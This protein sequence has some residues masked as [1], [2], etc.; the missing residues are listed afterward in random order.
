MSTPNLKFELSP[1]DSLAESFTSIPGQQY[2]SL[3]HT[4]GSME[5]L[6]AMTPQSFDGD[7]MFGD[8]MG[9]DMGLTG[10]LAGTPAPEKKQVKKRKSWGQQLPE[11]KTNLPPRKRAKTEDEKEQRRVERVLRNRRAAQTSRERKRQEVDNL[12]AEKDQIERRNT[13]LQLQLAD[14][15][16]RYEEVRRKLEEVT[17]MAGENITPACLP[18]SSVTSSPSR[19]ESFDGQSPLA[20]TKQL[21]GM[22]ESGSTMTSIRDSHNTMQ[23][24]TGTVDLASVSPP[25]PSMESNDEDSFNPSSFGMTQHSAAMLCDLQ[26][27]PKVQGH[28]MSTPQNILISRVLVST[29]WVQMMTSPVISNILIPLVQIK[30]SLMN[31]SVL[32]STP[33]LITLIIWLLTTTAPLTMPYSRTS[34]TKTRS[35]HLRPKYTLRIRL[36]RRLLTCSPSLAR[37][38]LDATLETMR[39]SS[40]QQ[41]AS[42][43]MNGAKV[44]DLRYGGKSSSLESL[45]TLS[46]AIKVIMKE[47]A[48]EQTS[49]ISKPDAVMNVE[50]SSEKDLFEF[51]EFSK[52]RVHGN[53]SVKDNSILG[54]KSLDGHWSMALEDDQ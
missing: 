19:K 40:N 18:P 22:E 51:R 45:I 48:K 39:L 12:Q 36:L 14:M 52:G 41:S 47:Q 21:F 15:Q 24:A 32:S 49:T 17:G 7:S 3:F 6:Q 38:L 20:F 13:D 31:G 44:F 8:D 28:W 27:Q 16:A 37:P 50:Q 5:P 4:E 10:S 29:L 1:A 30:L 33:S 2:P 25:P 9:E 43:C 35:H 42:D 23:S 11:P 53:S 54:E 26:C 46:W 34:F